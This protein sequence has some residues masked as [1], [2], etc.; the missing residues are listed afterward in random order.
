MVTI[1]LVRNLIVLAIPVRSFTSPS[2]TKSVPIPSI[3]TTNIRGIHNERRKIR[4][5]STKVIIHSKLQENEESISLDSKHSS[6]SSTIFNPNDRLSS[7]RK[8]FS[9]AAAEGFGTKA[10]NMA[11]SM[12]VGDIV[13][14]I[15]GNLELRQVLA[16]RG[17]YAGVEYEICELKTSIHD[18]DSTNDNDEGGGGEIITTMEGL[19]SATQNGVTAK[20]KPAY[21]LRDYLERSDWPVEVKPMEDVPLWLSKTTYEAGTMLGTLG[22]SFTYLS[23]A[24]IVAFFVRF[25]YVP[26]PSMQPALN[27]GD[28]VIVT[29]TIW[30]LKPAV[31]SVIL[32]DPPSEQLSRMISASVLAQ[33]NGASLPNKGEQFLKRVVA[34]GGERVGVKNSNTYTELALASSSDD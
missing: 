9:T 23:I 30:P 25:V 28:V 33:E 32:F 34:R 18:D 17:I 15:C 13:V 16:N 7:L 4:H 27:P 6:S 21:K 22:L 5:S 2:T 20:M 12:S 19:S 10:K 8:K 1:R 14:P 3:P 11:T 29:R 24:A 31:G 26:S